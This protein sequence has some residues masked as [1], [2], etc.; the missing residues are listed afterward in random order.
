MIPLQGNDFD[1]SLGPR[2]L[3]ALCLESLCATARVRIMAELVS[4][5]CV[6]CSG[7]RIHLN[8]IL[9]LI[10]VAFGY[11]RAFVAEP[12]KFRTSGKGDCDGDG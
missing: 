10:L 4:E 2:L 3:L 9:A 11:I 7:L 5:S 8:C 1:A 12:E 6:L